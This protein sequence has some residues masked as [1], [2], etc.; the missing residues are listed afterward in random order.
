MNLQYKQIVPA[1]LIG[2]L[3]GLWAGF[4]LPRISGHWHH[5]GLDT[6]RLLN[7][8]TKELQLDANQKDAAKEILESYSARIKTF[9]EEIRASMHSDIS[10][11]LS[12]E[13]QQKFDDLMKRWEARH[14]K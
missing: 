12:A 13:Q 7:K 1:L 3:L 5:S 14:K 11:L 2:C 6:E 10:H 9:H 4:F 8:F